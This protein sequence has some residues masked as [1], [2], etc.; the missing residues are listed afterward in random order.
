MDISARSYLTTGLCL[1]TAT[2]IAFTPLA[3]P[4]AHPPVPAPAF[5]TSAV[6]LAVSPADIE[7]AVAEVQAVFDAATASAAGVAGI[8]GQALIGVVDDIVVSIDTV[9]TS[10][11]AATGDPML[12]GSLAILKDLSVDA[13]A[14]LAYNLR[15]VNAV[16]TTTTAE[17][18]TLV[19]TAL[20][21]SLRNILTAAVNV[22]NEPLSPGSYVGLLAAGIASGQ[23][24]V[25]NGLGV[26]QAVAGAG[27]DLA[28]IAVHEVTFQL[29]NALG[30]LGDLLTHLGD[31]AGTPVA[32]AVADTVRG[33]AFAPALNA[34]PLEPVGQVTAPPA[35]GVASAVS[36]VEPEAAGK[37]LVTLPVA[38]A[39]TP[40]GDMS[41]DA[42]TT[43]GAGDVPAG[44]DA[45]D[46]GAE[47]P[48]AEDAV[49]DPVAAQEKKVP[50]AGAARGTFPKKGL[51]SS[52]RTAVRKA[53]AGASAGAAN[54]PPADTDTP[55]NASA[56]TATPHSDKA[57][58]ADGDA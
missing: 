1:T 21:G 15:R 46:T 4:A 54:H 35:A 25:G 32:E 41:S 37:R 9:F 45:H 20:T 31:A 43:T 50:T 47:E 29:N 30:G 5:T 7:A 57:D 36:S 34:R 14:M 8:P 17:V 56:E 39:P 40:P 55:Q 18:G 38:D 27:F 26:V 51:L 13:F 28:G 22:V 58:G 44:P 2:A 33:R 10:L 23:L 49:T 24:I 12:V 53:S 52:W 11:I 16:I 48:V 6:D 42:G 19:T 3:I